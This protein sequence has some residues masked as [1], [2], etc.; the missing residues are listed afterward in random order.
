[1]KRSLLSVLALS[2]AL[3]LVFPAV[4]ASAGWV[5]MALKKAKLA[6]SVRE[7]TYD[8]AL[9][10][11]IDRVNA[12]QY[13]LFAQDETVTLESGLSFRVNWAYADIP[14]WAE[15]REVSIGLTVLE[16]GKKNL[17]TSDFL[18]ATKD[19]KGDLYHRPWEI[20]TDT[21]SDVRVPCPMKRGQEIHLFY[22][23]PLEAEQAVFVAANMAGGK[24]SGDLRLTFVPL[25]T[26]SIRLENGTEKRID[27]VNAKRE[28][29]SAWGDDLLPNMDDTS[30]NPEGSVFLP[31]FDGEGAGDSLW[32]LK[33]TF[34]DGTEA[35]FP[36]LNLTKMFIV[37][38]SPKDGGGYALE[39]LR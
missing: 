12:G 16:P 9:E 27:R 10:S 8:E 31:I 28:E 15:S 34:E 36:G 3:C 17:E 32:E 33:I 19:E 20:L 38:L 13:R 22:R 14:L 6:K 29:A 23:V 30:I 11:C 26:L 21:Y 2:L 39:T 1:M 18:L 25:N 37:R 4:P 5:S 7:T 24:A 35:V